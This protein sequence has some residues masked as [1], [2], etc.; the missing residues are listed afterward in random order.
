M[1][2]ELREAVGQ[3]RAVV[4][5]QATLEALARSQVA[6]V[7][8]SEGDDTTPV[9]GATGEAAPLVDQLVAEL[10]EGADETPLIDVACWAALRSGAG[11]RSVP[12]SAV[13]GTVAALLRWE[14]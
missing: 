6:V 1:L 4:G 11:V 13:E 2:R 12:A 10:G 9:R 3:G 7:L 8:A 14:T 5:G